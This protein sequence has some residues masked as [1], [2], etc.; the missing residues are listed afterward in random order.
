MRRNRVF[1]LSTN[2]DNNRP[3]DKGLKKNIAIV[4]VFLKTILTFTAIFNGF[5][6]MTE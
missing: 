6:L 3:T 5:V 4:I 1:F 2:S